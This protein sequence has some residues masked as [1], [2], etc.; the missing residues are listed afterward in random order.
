MKKPL[1][2]VV[3]PS[4]NSEKHITESIQSIIDQT[5]L[6]WEFI[7]V[8]GHS[9]D[10]TIDIIKNFMDKDP[11][12]RLLFDERKG[13]GPAL[14]MGCEAAQG[15]YIARMDTDDVSLPERLEK[16][17]EYLERHE[18]TVLVSCCANFFDDRGT[19]VGQ[20]F[21][22][23]W[24]HIIRHCATTILHPGVMMRKKEYEETGG[25]PPIKRAE[26]LM[27]WY[28]LL[29]LGDVKILNDILVNYRTSEEALS[30]YT[31]E[32]FNMNVNKR[33]KKYAEKPLDSSSLKEIEDFVNENITTVSV[34]IKRTKSVE[35]KA[36][37]FFCKCFPERWARGLVLFLKNIYGLK[38][39]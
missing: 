15:K 30:N 34:K 29:K 39:L 9:K 14:N 25:Y 13:I 4:Y 17:V 6:D 12:I 11:R 5:F 1:V 36:Y 27:L 31:T 32:Y 20:F 24:P 2:S 3:M 16:E 23:T 19:I 33:W 35:E 38:K 37:G 28:R 18:N 8:D 21:P 22:Y 7:I 26:D 10:K